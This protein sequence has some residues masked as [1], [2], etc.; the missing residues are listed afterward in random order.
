[1]RK[2]LPLIL[3]AAC[4]LL[5]AGCWNGRAIL[6]FEQPHWDTLGRARSLAARLAVGALTNGYFP[7]IQVIAGSQSAMDRVV[8][9]AGSVGRG[10]VVVGP[11]LSYEWGGYVTRFPHV[12]FILLADVTESAVPPNVTL[13]TF[14]RRAAFHEAGARAAEEAA[15]AGGHLALLTSA[16]SDITEEELAA[17]RDGA[18]ATAAAVAPDTRE[19]PATADRASVQSAVGDLRRAGVSVVLIGLG[20]ADPWALDALKAVGGS[21]VLADWQASGADPQQVL[22][23]VEEDIPA[24]IARALHE[25]SRGAQN[26]AGPVFL[27]RGGAS[28]GRKI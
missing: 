27:A 4:I 5:L 19:L 13:L 18:K 11:L 16:A 24:G 8:R 12:R 9:A 26:A 20:S 17:F 22:L 21:A 7:S 3:C 28:A 6:L 25:A 10:A 1:M 23:S 2:P 15:A 14:D